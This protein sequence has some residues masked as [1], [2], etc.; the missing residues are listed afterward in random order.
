MLVDVTTIP[1]HVLE[2]DGLL[3]VQRVNSSLC[4]RS[5]FGSIV[6][7]IKRMFLN[8]QVCSIKHIFRSA[9][10]AAHT[11][12]RLCENSPRCVSRGVIPDSIREIICNDILVM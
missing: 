4:D 1:P 12:A 11:L 3:M 2:S 9:N 8:F 10:V 7:D 6:D 5:S